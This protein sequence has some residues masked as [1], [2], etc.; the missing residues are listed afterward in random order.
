MIKASGVSLVF[1]V[2]PY[3]QDINV[4]PTEQLLY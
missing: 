1:G 4:Q 2:I 3:L